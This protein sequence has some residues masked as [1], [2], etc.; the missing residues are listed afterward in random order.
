MSAPLR[1]AVREAPAGREERGAA[2]LE[3]RGVQLHDGRQARGHGAV[4]HRHGALERVDVEGADRA[5]GLA[6]LAQQPT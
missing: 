3:G 1:A 5:P 2:I 6:R 4:A